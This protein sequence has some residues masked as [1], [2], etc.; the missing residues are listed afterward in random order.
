MPFRICNTLATFQP[1]M[2]AILKTWWKCVWRFSWMAYLCNLWKVVQRCEKKNLILNRKKMSFHCQW[3]DIM[4]GYNISRIGIKVD[5]VKI[6]AIEKLNPSFL[7]Y[8]RFYR[9][10]MK[11]FL[12]IA[13]PLCHLS[14]KNR[15]FIFY[16]QCRIAFKELKTCQTTTP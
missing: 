9:K 12:R 11:D 16:E 8:V 3:R 5:R 4:L 13:K 2:I 10:F 14:E 15:K 6:E 7:S 1:F